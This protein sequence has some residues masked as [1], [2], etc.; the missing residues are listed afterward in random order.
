[1]ETMKWWVL[2]IIFDVTSKGLSNGYQPIHLVSLVLSSSSLIRESE[3][4]IRILRLLVTMF[5]AYFNSQSIDCLSLWR[6][7]IP[8]F[9][10]VCVWQCNLLPRSSAANILSAWALP[11][12]WTLEPV[13]FYRGS[14]AQHSWLLP[15]VWPR[16]KC[17]GPV[18]FDSLCPQCGVISACNCFWY[19]R[20]IPLLIPVSSLWYF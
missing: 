17:A 5:F 14:T 12:P 11:W 7:H 10:N 4:A 3:L 16:S 1:M 8:S 18:D 2:K 15:L 6:N 13:R 19:Y 20:R 9:G